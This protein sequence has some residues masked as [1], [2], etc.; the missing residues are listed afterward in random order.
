MESVRKIKKITTK[1]IGQLREMLGNDRELWQVA[2]NVKGLVKPGNCSENIRY[3][4]K[5]KRRSDRYVTN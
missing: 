1:Y 3:G 4:L 5:S 2:E